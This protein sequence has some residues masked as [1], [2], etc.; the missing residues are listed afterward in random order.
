[1]AVYQKLALDINR[2]SVYDCITVKQADDGRFLDINLLVDGTPYIVPQNSLVILRAIKPD[3][4]SIFN[5]GGVNSDGSV[6]VYLSSQLTA[7][8]GKV[9]A[10]V[11]VYN[12][13]TKV[14][15]VSFVIL[16]RDIPA[17]VD[18]I[19]SSDE[20]DVLTTVSTNLSDKVTGKGISMDL[21][22]GI[23]YVTEVN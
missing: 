8:V 5:Y 18:H 2:E 10:D 22:N 23:L 14:S 11:N 17:N 1:M 12:N 19:V 9:Y 13:G 3:N 15:S 20:Y 7:A 4:K 16:V 21:I 6:R